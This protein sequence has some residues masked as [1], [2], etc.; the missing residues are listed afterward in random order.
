VEVLP[1]RLASQSYVVP[2]MYIFVCLALSALSPYHYKTV[3][4]SSVVGEP[5]FVFFH[6]LILLFR[7]PR[8]SLTPTSFRNDA[9]PEEEVYPVG[10]AAFETSFVPFAGTGTS[11]PR[12]D[13]RGMDQC[14]R[15]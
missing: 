2:D 12:G 9:T 15:S 3:K 8:S 14:T 5:S 11:S 7:Y 13:R 1:I 6:G 4:Y 10:K